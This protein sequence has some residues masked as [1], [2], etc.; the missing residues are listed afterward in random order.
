V[1]VFTGSAFAAANGAV[2]GV[3]PGSGLA[4]VGTGMGIVFDLS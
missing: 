4:A 3:L 2:V 1:G